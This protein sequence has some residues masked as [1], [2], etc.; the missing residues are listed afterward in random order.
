MCNCR[1]LIIIIALLIC[2]SLYA[3]DADAIVRNAASCS[4]ADVLA[5]Y[6]SAVNG[7]II[8]VP[9]GDCLTTN[10]WPSYLNVTK[11]VTFQG[12]GA[13]ITLIGTSSTSAGF[14]VQADNVVITGFT[15]NCE[16]KN[17]SN[18]GIIFVGNSSTNPTYNYKNW[19]FH[20]NTFTNCGAAST[21]ETG[22][23]AI[24][25]FGF[26][27]GLI[28]HNT[29]NDCN[30]E[31][32]NICADGAQH[33]ERSHAFGQYDNGT[34]FIE[35]NTFN[36]TNTSHNY[37]NIIDGNSQQRFTFR[38][39]TININDGVRYGSAIVSTH[40]TC[41]TCSGSSTTIGDA[42]S[43]NYEMYDNTINLNNTGMMRDLGIVRGG[44]ALIYNN[45]ITFTGSSSGRYDVA[46]WLSNYRSFAKYG[47]LS[48]FC[49]AATHPRGDSEACHEVDSG[50]ITEGLEANKTTLNGAI[51]ASQTTI[52]LASALGFS[53]NSVANGFSI[54]IDNEQIDYTGIS[55]TLL[56][57]AVR[58]ANGTTAASHSN[59]ASVNYLKFGVCLE[60]VN[61][62]YIWNNDING[63]V[64]S[65][66]NDV[67]V[68]GFKNGCVGEA[69][70]DYTA[71]DIQSFT[72]RPNN[73]QYRTGTAFSYTPYPY[74]HPLVTGTPLPS[75]PSSPKNLKIQ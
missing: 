52:T 26:V 8:S 71:Y 9:A 41:V 60:Q 2:C 14:Q 27:Y 18:H 29:F 45:H 17:T 59:G 15:F 33:L 35:D 31:C 4:R 75:P 10:K 61:N 49:S 20:H 7:D 12:A 43:A 11:Q 53:L 44:R 47:S 40:E 69:G 70:P 19:R 25:L 24:T 28:D 63:S 62:V 68:C 42:G 73:F 21:W 54:K 46:S 1:Q 6:N 57:G 50:Y 58:G 22:Y 39:N 51:D 56:T 16:Y 55:G 38:H 13:G 32:F 23:D 37:E 64:T 3:F 65:D 5:A 48:G 72:Q 34:I 74:P 66:M 30:G 36:A 67:F